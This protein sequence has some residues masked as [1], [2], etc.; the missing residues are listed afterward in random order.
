MNYGN[1]IVHEPVNCAKC[2][3]LDKLLFLGTK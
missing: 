1:V 2:F 3:G